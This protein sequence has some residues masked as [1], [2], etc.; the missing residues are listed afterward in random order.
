MGIFGA[1]LSQCES[2]EVL[3]ECLLRNAV[4]W[5]VEQDGFSSEVISQAR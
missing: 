5:G 2:P 3:R 4:I 1:H